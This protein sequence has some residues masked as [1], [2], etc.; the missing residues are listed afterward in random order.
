VAIDRTSAGEDV[1]ITFV[2]TETDDPVSVVGSFNDWTPGVH[3]LEGDVGGP[4][5]VSIVVPA[6]VEVHFRYLGSDGR[7]FDDPDAD[8]ITAE[9]SILRPVTPNNRSLEPTDNLAD[10]DDEELRGE[11]EPAVS[12]A[13]NIS[14]TH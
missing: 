13:A 2:L 9:G 4:R 1:T 14:D 5:S 11:T 10:R 12:A 6:D 3:L 7:W 8:E